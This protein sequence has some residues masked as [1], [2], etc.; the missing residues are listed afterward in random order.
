MSNE[1][2]KL[3]TT[4]GV[5]TIETNY[6]QQQKPLHDFKRLSYKKYSSSCPTNKCCY[7][8]DNLAYGFSNDIKHASQV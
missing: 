4:H 3:D 7:A 6:P 8:Y 5:K 1:K 2:S